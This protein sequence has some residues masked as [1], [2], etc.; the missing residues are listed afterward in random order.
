MEPGD[1]RLKPK[2][3]APLIPEQVNTEQLP[4]DLLNILSGLDPRCFRTQVGRRSGGCSRSPWPGLLLTPSFQEALMLAALRECSAEEV[5][6]NPGDPVAHL[7]LAS[8]SAQTPC[9]TPWPSSSQGKLRCSS[10]AFRVATKPWSGKS[11][12]RQDAICQVTDKKVYEGTLTIQPSC[13]GGCID[14]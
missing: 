9:S 7:R 5:P 14:K 8:P 12:T 3:Y 13:E 4:L 6:S 10:M 1:F 2:K 11:L